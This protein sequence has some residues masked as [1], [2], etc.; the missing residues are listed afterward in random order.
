MMMWKMLYYDVNFDQT[1]LPNM[2]QKW[3]DYFD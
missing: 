1:D 3:K 2:T